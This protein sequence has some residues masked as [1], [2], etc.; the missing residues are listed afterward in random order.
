[1]AGPFAYRRAQA[2]V[3]LWLTL[4]AVA[5]VAF[6]REGGFRC[7]GGR[8]GVRLT[9]RSGKRLRSGSHD[10]ERLAAMIAARIPPGR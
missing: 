3:A 2:L 5:K 8:F 9:L 1:M 4:P 7:A 10:H 6:S